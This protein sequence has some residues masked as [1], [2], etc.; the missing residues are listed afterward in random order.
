MLGIALAV[1]HPGELGDLGLHDRLGEHPD[2]LTQE[3]DVAVG[4]RLA[5]GLEHGHPVLGH[6]GV[7][8]C[9]RFLVRRREDDA[10]AASFHGLR[11][12]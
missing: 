2:P 3:V 4:D 11:R 10:V 6:R 8:P 7:P 5:H 12:L 9:R 1:G